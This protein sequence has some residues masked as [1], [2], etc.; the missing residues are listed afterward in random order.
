MW[1]LDADALIFPKDVS[2]TVGN[3]SNIRHLVLQVHY[4]SKDKIPDTGDTSGVV[5]EYQTEQ[6]EF[7]A[8]RARHSSCPPPPPVQVSCLSTFTALWLLTLSPT[9]TPRVVCW[10]GWI[11]DYRIVRSQ[12]IT[13]SDSVWE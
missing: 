8:G 13:S 6:T 10:V 9:G 4:I 12:E 1:S 2:L 5:V 7:A 3:N 11:K